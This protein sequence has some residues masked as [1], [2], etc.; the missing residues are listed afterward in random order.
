MTRELMR[1]GMAIFLVAG[2]AACGEDAPA[3]P[4]P[5]GP[6]GPR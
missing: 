4:A 6:S 1:Y 2:L 5:R 3:E